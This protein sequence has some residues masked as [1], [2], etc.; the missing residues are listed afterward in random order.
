MSFPRKRESLFNQDILYFPYRYEILPRASLGWNDNILSEPLVAWSLCG[1]I[2]LT[3]IR[4]VKF[5]HRFNPFIKVINPER[6]V[7]GVD[8]I[9]VKPEAKHNGFDVQDFFK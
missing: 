8:I 1:S 5:T 6:L 7:G 9:A 2:L 3:R 4:L